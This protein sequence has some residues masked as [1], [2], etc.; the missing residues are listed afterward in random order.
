MTDLAVDEKERIRKYLLERAEA[1]EMSA[2]FHRD[3]EDTFKDRAYGFGYE[4]QAH[5]LRNAVEQMDAT[6]RFMKMCEKMDAD[7]GR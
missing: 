5:A 6:L 4:M 2:S 3:K 7:D 1:A